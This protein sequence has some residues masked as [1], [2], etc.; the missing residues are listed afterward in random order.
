MKGRLSPPFFLFYKYWLGPGSLQITISKWIVLQLIRYDLGPDI[1]FSSGE[2]KYGWIIRGFRKNLADLITVNSGNM[3]WFTLGIQNQ[4]NG[5]KIKTNGVH[6]VRYG[7]IFGQN[8]AH[9][10][11]EAF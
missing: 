4:T 8:E 10:L 11:Q 9:R 5:V 2:G 1:N 7:P 6:M 3:S